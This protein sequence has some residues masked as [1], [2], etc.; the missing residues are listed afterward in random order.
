MVPETARGEARKQT[1]TYKQVGTLKIQADVIREPDDRQRPVVVWIHGGALIMGHRES[2]PAR[3]QEAMLEAGYCLVSIDYRLAPETRLPEVIAD[4][5]YALLWVHDRGPELFHADPDRIAV[6]GGSAGGYLTLT[7]GF[8]AKHRPRAL[9]SL[10]GYGD[11]VG[12]WFSEP[13]KHPRHNTIQ[14]TRDQAWQQVQG[15]PV[16]DAR[17]RR[18]DGGAFYQ[19]CRQTGSW[20]QAVTG[21]DP[22][23]EPEKFHPYMAL[24]NITREYPP[25]FLIHGETDTDVPYEQST[26]IADRLKA[27]GVEHHLVGLANAEHGLQ[28]G[29]PQAIDAAYREAFAFLR[30][31]LDR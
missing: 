13:S 7:A 18:G 26:L 2:V 24:Q 20:P 1:F 12:A 31:H 11:L 9:L 4:V 16:S 22:H 30:R 5:E 17:D 23:R 25:T 27:E 3:L 10:W 8:R 28:G 19:Y 21:W 14:V 15:L 6:T 29:D